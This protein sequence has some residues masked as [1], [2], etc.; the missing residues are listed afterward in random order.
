MTT[1]EATWSAPLHSDDTNTD[2]QEICSLQKQRALIEWHLRQAKLALIIADRV[3]ADSATRV[4]CL[5]KQV[6]KMQREREDIQ[7]KLQHAY[8]GELN[9]LFA[10][11]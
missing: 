11:D 6:D 3:A 9:E 2:E 4:E 10:H 5:A 1:E 8:Q 7:D